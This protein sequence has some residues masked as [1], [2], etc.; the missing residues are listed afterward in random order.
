MLDHFACGVVA[1]MAM[2][3]DGVRRFVQR[4]SVKTGGLVVSAAAVAV[5]VAMFHEWLPEK[6]FNGYWDK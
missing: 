5:T 1:A 6:V 4:R 2:Q 3:M